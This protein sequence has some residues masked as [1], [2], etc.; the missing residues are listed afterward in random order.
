MP[1]SKL[2][3]SV[4]MKEGITNQSCKILMF[5]LKCTQDQANPR[6]IFHFGKSLNNKPE[7]ILTQ[8]PQILV[9]P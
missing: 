8:N 2:F 6:P 1:K 4:S 7:P 9:K 3:V 5:S